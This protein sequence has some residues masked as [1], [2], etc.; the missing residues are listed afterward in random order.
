MMYEDIDDWTKQ[1]NRYLKITKCAYWI[2]L[3]GEEPTENVGTK[4]IVI[5]E[6]QLLTADSL[7]DLMIRASKGERL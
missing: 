6:N 4:T 7:K 2:N 1:T 3:Q 5:N